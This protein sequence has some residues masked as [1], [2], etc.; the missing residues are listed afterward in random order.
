MKG[1]S[2]V[3]WSSCPVNPASEP[4]APGDPLAIASVTIRESAAPGLLFFPSRV[5][6]LAGS[7]AHILCLLLRFPAG[8]FPP[9]PQ[10]ADPVPADLK[11]LCCRGR[12]FLHCH[13]SVCPCRGTKSLSSSFLSLHKSVKASDPSDMGYNPDVLAFYL[14]EPL[15]EVGASLSHPWV[16]RFVQ[17]SISTFK[18][19]GGDCSGPLRTGRSEVGTCSDG[20]SCSTSRVLPQNKRVGKIRPLMFH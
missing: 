17:D 5:W 6:W 9:P 4:A 1:N 11:G 13:G 12:R 3:G 8:V 20:I 10:R 16:W 15:L 19:G 2:H 18:A 7:F 14:L